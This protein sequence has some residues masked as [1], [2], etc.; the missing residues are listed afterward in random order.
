MWVAYGVLVGAPPVIVANSCARRGRHGDVEGER[1]AVRRG[2]RRAVTVV[3]RSPE[4]RRRSAMLRGMTRLT[5]FSTVLTPENFH[6]ESSFRDQDGV[7][8]QCT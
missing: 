6:N 3:R 8:K 1:I 7:S 4:E 5:R 2:N